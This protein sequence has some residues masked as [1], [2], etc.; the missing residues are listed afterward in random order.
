MF[1]VWTE[2]KGQVAEDCFYHFIK[3]KTRGLHISKQGFRFAFRKVEGKAAWICKGTESHP[4]FKEGLPRMYEIMASGLA[5]YIIDQKEKEQLE[6]ILARECVNM[7][8]DELERV[9]L[10]CE[11]L[12]KSRFE[13]DQ[14]TRERRHDKLTEGLIEG[15]KEIPV[16]HLEGTLR[17]RLQ[18]Y[19][20]ELHEIVEYALD[21]FYMDRQY[22]EFMS[23]LKYFVYFQET[24]VPLIHVVH[25]DKHEFVLFDE[26]KRP[27]ALPPDDSV[28]MEMPG[29]ELEME[30]EDMI[31]SRLISISPKK[32]KLHTRTPDFPV[33][34]SI[35]QIF[36][37]RVEIC[38]NCKLCR[39]MKE[40]GQL[41]LDEEETLEL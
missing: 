18:N 31:I 8:S 4:G 30:V 9:K 16:I 38:Q 26:Y 14:G 34:R 28:I 21:E 7:D 19:K 1:A 24:K 17:F 36:E 6:R 33:I 20:N 40:T 13:S 2:V 39:G 3:N 29:I 37:D 23:L 10:I 5:D 25:R 12:L 22:E 15:L 41:P 35:T 11:P 32:M 27:M